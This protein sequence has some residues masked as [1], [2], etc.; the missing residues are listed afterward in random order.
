M[1]I[2][3]STDTFSHIWALLAPES[4]FR[5]REQA[6]R[7]IWATFSLDKQRAIYLRIRGKKQRGEQVSP[8]PYFA[9]IDNI[10][11]APPKL[12]P[13]KNYNGSADF[14]QMVK[15]GTLVTAEYQGEVGIYTE[16]DA[17]KHAMTIIKHLQP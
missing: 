5:S 15:T 6:C 1:D 16:A 10:D 4:E 14:L 11:P 9:I 17:T 2:N 7:R 12:Q 3:S 13:P 8:N